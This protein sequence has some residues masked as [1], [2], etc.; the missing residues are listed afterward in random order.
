MESTGLFQ[1]FSPNDIKLL[2]QDDLQKFNKLQ[3]S[4][5]HLGVSSEDQGLRQ[6]LEYHFKED[7]NSDTPL[8]NLKK[9]GTQIT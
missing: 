5:E 9:E 6:Y 3:V 2:N 4:L 8:D 1:L 7:S